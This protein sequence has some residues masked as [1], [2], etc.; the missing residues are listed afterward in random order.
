M[1]NPKTT[2]SKANCTIGNRQSFS[3]RQ[4]LGL[5]A[6]TPLLGSD[7]SSRTKT[8]TGYGAFRATDGS[9]GIVGINLEDGLPLFY[10]PMP[11]RGHDLALSPDSNHL[12]CM[13]RRPGKY[14]SVMDASQ[15][16]LITQQSAAKGR[17]FYGHACFSADGRYLF[18]TENDFEGARGVIGVRDVNR[19]YQQVAEWSAHGVGPHQLSLSASGEHVLVAIGGIQTHPNS[20]REKL[21]LDSMQSALVYLNAQNGDLIARY[22]LPESQ[23]SLSIRHMAVAK[24]G[25]VGLAFQDQDDLSQHNTLVGFHKLGQSIKT[26]AAEETIQRQMRGYCA[27]IAKDVSGGWFAVTSPRGNLITFW[28]AAK[29]SYISFAGL[30]DCSGIAP[31][32]LEGEFVV[33]S[34]RGK[35]MLINAETGKQRHLSYAYSTGNM[36]W[37]N[38]FITRNV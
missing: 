35:A 10:T 31:T 17:H 3:R 11:S 6:L 16:Q 2:R 29:Q 13:A 14:L 20:G 1:A 22:T 25:L 38:H 33:T 32:N 7:L 12:L 23:R 26:K 34:G 27:S 37:D 9:Y 21:N 30:G 5:I 15:G 18:T 19:G 28:N 8:T 36:A 4:I 24:D